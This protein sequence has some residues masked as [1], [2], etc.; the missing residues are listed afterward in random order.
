[1]IHFVQYSL[2][3]VYQQIAG[4]FKSNSSRKLRVMNMR[5]GEERGGEKR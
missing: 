2:A 3:T 1:V 5:K 4:N